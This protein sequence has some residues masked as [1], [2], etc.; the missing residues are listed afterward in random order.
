MALHQVRDDLEGLGHGQWDFDDGNPA[1]RDCLGAK[2]GVLLRGH[3]NRGNDPGFLDPA[4]HLVFLHLVASIG[5]GLMPISAKL[6][7]AIQRSWKP[8]A[9]KKAGFCLYLSAYGPS[10]WASLDRPLGGSPA[11]TS[12]PSLAG[13]WSAAA[14]LPLCLSL[15]YWRG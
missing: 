3:A 6:S 1:L 12:R 14:K 5:A 15:A 10:A 13:F 9:Q 4:P 2:K 8:T 11:H 7:F